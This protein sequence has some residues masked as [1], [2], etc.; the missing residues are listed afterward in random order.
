VLV[1]CYRHRENKFSK[2]INEGP[3]ANQCHVSFAA[4]LTIL[5]PSWQQN[6]YCLLYITGHKL[7]QA[8]KCVVVWHKRAG[9]FHVS[10]GWAGL[11]NCWPV[12]SLLA[13]L[14]L[15]NAQFIM[16][17]V[18]QLYDVLRIDSTI[19]S[20]VLINISSPKLNNQIFKNFEA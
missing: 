20:Y 16:Q 6:R 13:V 12:P 18:F 11:Q 2:L 3:L 19:V 10:S 1:S 14:V 8:R 9:Q 7:V 4:I 17:I 15:L 5:P